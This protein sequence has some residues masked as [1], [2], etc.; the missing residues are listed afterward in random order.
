[1]KH[2]IKKGIK[3]NV[4]LFDID[5]T[6]VNS[7]LLFEHYLHLC[8]VGILKPTKGLKAWVKNKKC[9]KL[10][11]EVAN[12][13]QQE[14]MK[15][16]YNIVS[17]TAIDTVNRLN[18]RKFNKEALKLIAKDKEEGTLSILISGS[19]KYLVKP[20]AQR[21]G[22][23]LIGT[24]LESKDGVLTGRI[25]GHNCRC[26]QK[27]KRLEEIYGPL[28]QYHIRAWGD[29]RGDYEMLATAS[30]AHWRH[31]HPEWARKKNP[32]TQFR[33]EFMKDLT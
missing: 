13:Y 21:L 4:S 32:I 19:P 3:G 8:R 29:T 6:I 10:I 18:T 11:T 16:N 25:I 33:N 5:G 28:G 30:D 2:S 9:D 27:I 24:Q 20:F 31:F 23:K 15:L 17:Q 1:M 7:S 14:V 22:V 26:I 12:E